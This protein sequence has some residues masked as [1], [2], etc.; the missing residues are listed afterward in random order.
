MSVPRKR[1]RDFSQAA[2]LAVDIATGQV[3]GL[4]EPPTISTS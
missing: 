1:P 4:A 2:K 3:E